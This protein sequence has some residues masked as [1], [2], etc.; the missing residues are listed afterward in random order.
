MKYFVVVYRDEGGYPAYSQVVER[1]D[2][3]N[4]LSAKTLAL[5]LLKKGCDQIKICQV[6]LK[7]IY[8]IHDAPPGIGPGCRMVEIPSK[9]EGEF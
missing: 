2:S 7:P 5:E 3:L 6:Y 8:E 4:E 9:F 1:F